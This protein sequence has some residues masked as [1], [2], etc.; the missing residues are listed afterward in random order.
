MTRAGPTTGSDALTGAL[1]SLEIKLRIRT[2]L[3]YPGQLSGRVDGACLSL[4]GLDGANIWHVQVH[5]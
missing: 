3:I 1:K 5:Q 4:L 2:C